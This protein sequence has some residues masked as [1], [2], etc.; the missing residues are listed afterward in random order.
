ME[1][2]N[3]DKLSASFISIIPQTIQP[4]QC[5]V[6]EQNDGEFIK[7]TQTGMYMVQMDAHFNESCMIIICINDKPELTTISLS[8]PTNNLHIVIINQVLELNKGDVISFKNYGAYTPIS[9]TDTFYSILDI[10]QFKNVNLNLY[11][12]Y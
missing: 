6:F 2:T 10:N 1:L 3:I 4:D 5:I 9:T 12:I 7:I 8:T 11:K